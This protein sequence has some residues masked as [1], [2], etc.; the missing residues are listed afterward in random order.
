MRNGHIVYL[1]LSII[2]AAQCGETRAGEVGR[3]DPKGVETGK[4]CGDPFWPSRQY[5]LSGDYFCG[6]ERTKWPTEMK[7]MVIG[8]DKDRYSDLIKEKRDLIGA[9]TGATIYVDL[10]PNVVFI[11]EDSISSSD[12]IKNLIRS[13]NIKL[14]QDGTHLIESYKNIN[15]SPCLTVVVSKYNFREPAMFLIAET[16]RDPGHVRQCIER[17]FFDY[18]HVSRYLNRF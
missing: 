11:L 5:A 6:P 4:D 16:S 12:Q 7:Y 3:P 15:G 17:G 9:I 10:S 2:W 8:D 14:N 1:F 13:S 18:F